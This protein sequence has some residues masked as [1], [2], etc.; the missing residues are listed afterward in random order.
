MWILSRP[1][2][3]CKRVI[4]SSDFMPKSAEAQTALRRYMAAVDRMTGE[5]F[6]TGG[7]GFAG[8]AWRPRS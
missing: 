1:K 3:N 4:D 8:S 2:A 7:R 5:R 6:S